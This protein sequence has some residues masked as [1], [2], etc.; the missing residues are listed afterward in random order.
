MLINAN[1]SSVSELQRTLDDLLPGRF[2]RCAKRARRLPE[3]RG[4]VTGHPMK[5]D[6]VP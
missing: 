3:E 6:M 4:V 1:R 5:M 2:A